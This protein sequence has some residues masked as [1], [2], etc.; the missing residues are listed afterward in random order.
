[1]TMNQ[2][3]GL[4]D[5]VKVVLNRVGADTEN[6]ISVRKAEEILGKPI[7]WQIPNDTKAMIGARNVGVPLIQHAPR[8]KVQQALH[9]LAGT[10][11]GKN[12]NGKPQAAAGFWPWR[13]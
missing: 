11:C 5:K 10:L 2:E 4:V 8:S 12:G 13:K 7:Y 9:A 3:E 1:M 6:G